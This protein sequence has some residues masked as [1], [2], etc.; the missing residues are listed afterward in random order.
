MEAAQRW[1]TLAFPDERFIKFFKVMQS[2]QRPKTT[3]SIN[4]TLF[5]M[6]GQVQTTLN[7]P[8]FGSQDI[9]FGSSSHFCTMYSKSNL[10]SEKGTRMEV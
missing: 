4:K 3:T 2:G 5:L 8:Y 10:L 6:D 1:V 7:V 9:K